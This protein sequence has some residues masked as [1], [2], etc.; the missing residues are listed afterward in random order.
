MRFAMTRHRMPVSVR[1]GG[2]EEQTVSLS[3]GGLWPWDGRPIRGAGGY[4][5]FLW[6][7]SPRTRRPAP[8]AIP[9]A[10]RFF[11][12]ERKSILPY[13]KDKN[14]PNEG[15]CCS[16]KP[17]PLRWVSLC[18]WVQAG[19]RASKATSR[20]SWS[21][22]LWRLRRAFLF[23]SK[24]RRARILLLLASK[25]QSLRWSAAWKGKRFPW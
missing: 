1:R 12:M 13:T 11:S 6:R 18:F 17:Q 14:R 15:V 9:R 24:P 16:S 25:L 5:S 8:R 2:P 10:I 22:A 3:S 19:E 20:A 21:Q 4:R 7:K 23:H